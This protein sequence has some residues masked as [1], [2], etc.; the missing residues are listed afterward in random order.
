[1][2]AIENLFVF[3]R[4]VPIRQSLFYIIIAAFLPATAP[5]FANLLAN[6]GFEAGSLTNWST[7]GPNNYV[8]NNSGIAHNGTYFYKVYGQFNNTNNYTCIYQD[9]PSAAGAIYSA[10]GWAY[11]SS[12]DSIR[13]EDETW[14]A[15]SFLDSS[16]NALALYQSAII[17]SNNISAFGGYSKWF[18]LQV[19][20]QCSYTNASALVLLPAT[21]TSTASSLV[22]PSG[23]AYVRCQIVFAQGPD[24]A[25]GSMYFDDLTLSQTGGTPVPAPATQ[26]DIVWDDEF[27]GTSINTNLWTFETGNNGGWG[28]GELEYYTSN[29]LNAYENGGMLHIV[30]SQQGTNGCQYTSARMKTENAFSTSYGRIVWRAA[31]PSGTGMWPALWMLGAD[32]PNPGI[33]WPA[34]GEIDAVEENGAT[35]NLIQSSLHFGNSGDQDVTETALYTFPAGINATNFHTYMVDWEYGSISF[36]VDGNVFETQNNW[37][38][39]EAPYPAPFNAPFFLVMNLAVGGNYVG[40]PTTNAINAGTTFP[41]QMLVDYVRVYQQTAPLAIS[42]VNQSGANFTL[43]WPTNIVCH[44]QVQT[45]SLLGNWSDVTGATNPFVL[46]AASTT[47]A[48]F[49]RLESP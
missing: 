15:V 41:A 13:G 47:N 39:P 9:S 26:W 28:N 48:V 7:F 24:N 34:C 5:A 37:S 42:I 1:M 17:T 3:W 4:K 10:N 33:G 40:N 6:P 25:N 36:S 23:T 35:N 19:T 32:F 38:S 27:N 49:Y 30:A 20:N 44:L 16:H 43:A 12:S 18:D 45:N 29:S 31:L 14:I 46:S 11:S 21:A 22:A 2:N 8:I